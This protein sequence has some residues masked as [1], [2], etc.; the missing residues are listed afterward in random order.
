MLATRGYIVC[1]MMDPAL[2]EA[3]TGALL[4]LQDPFK[5]QSSRKAGEPMAK[6][7]ESTKPYCSYGCPDASLPSRPRQGR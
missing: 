6:F 1:A 4:P 7:L 5:L 2:P 3:A